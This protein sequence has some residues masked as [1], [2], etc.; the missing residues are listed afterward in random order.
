MSRRPALITQ[1][2]VARVIRAAKAEGVAAVEID[3]D[4]TI[5]IILKASPS[6]TTAPGAVEE[7]REIVL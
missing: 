4:G 1:A 5:R 2:E 7:E 6:P 3:R